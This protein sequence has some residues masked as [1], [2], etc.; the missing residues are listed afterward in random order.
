MNAENNIIGVDGF[1]WTLDVLDV[2]GKV[3][4]SETNKNLI[5][6]AGMSFLVRAPFGDATPI[7]TFYLGLYRGNYVPSASTV[8]ADIPTNM[9]EFID[10]SEAQRPLWDRA[11]DGVSSMDNSTAK[12]SF[13]VTQDRTIYGAFLVSSSGKGSNGGLVL[14]CVRFA[15]PKQVTAGQTINLSGGLTYVSTNVI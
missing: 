15:S 10:Y 4:D 12:A 11:F 6:L 8:A 13:T 9:N 5:P 2:S 3:I 7:T 1:K 14:S